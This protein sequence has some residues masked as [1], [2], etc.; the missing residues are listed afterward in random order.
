[1]SFPTMEKQQ[2][3]TLR[4]VL[5]GAFVVLVSCGDGSTPTSTDAGASVAYNVGDTGPGGGIIVYVDEAG[6]NN[7][8]SYFFS[9]HPCLTGRCRFLEMAPTDIYGVY[10]WTDALNAAVDY[11]TATADDWRL[12]SQDAL[13]EMCKYAF[14]DTV[15]VICNDSGRGP[16]SNSVGG[17]RTGV[18][19]SSSKF[20]DNLAWH[21]NFFFGGQGAGDKNYPEW[22]RP[23]RA[24][25]TGEEQSLTRK[26]PSTTTYSPT[27]TIDAAYKVGDTGP[28]GGIIIWVDVHGFGRVPDHLGMSLQMC[29]FGTCYYIEMAPADLEGTFYSSD[30]INA[31]ENYTTATADDWWLPSQDALD[32]MC[33]YANYGSTNN[34]FCSRSGAMRDGFRLD[35]YWAKATYLPCRSVWQSFYDG[36][37]SC[38]HYEYAV[39][40][41][42]PVRA[43]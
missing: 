24:F 18:Y 15:N 5:A 25:Y 31:A 27:T 21:Q 40:S 12:P 17:F 11:S 28:G 43:F 32:A 41:V 23:V 34:G 14:M 19:W 36:D 16:F 7:S 29:P 42:R 1:M 22:V 8:N 4:W 33:I 37:V 3:R 38:N 6:F 39:A 10:S 26:T 9:G 20:D 13:N 30:A 35:K 2:M